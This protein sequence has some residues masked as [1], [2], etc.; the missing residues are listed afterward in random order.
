VA[1]AAADGADVTAGGQQVVDGAVL[2]PL[3]GTV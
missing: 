1:A 2:R 3:G